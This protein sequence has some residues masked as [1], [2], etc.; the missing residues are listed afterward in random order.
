MDWLCVQRYAAD[1]HVNGCG[2]VEGLTSYIHTSIY[3]CILENSYHQEKNPGTNKVY[4]SMDDSTKTQ[5]P[6]VVVLGSGW[7]AMSFIKSLPE[8]IK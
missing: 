2:R 4:Y 6:R 1:V 5:K 3:L 7:G 8:N